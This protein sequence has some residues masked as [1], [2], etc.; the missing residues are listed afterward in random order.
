MTEAALA[1]V[2]L[3]VLVRTVLEVCPYLWRLAT[4]PMVDQGEI[5][6]IEAEIERTSR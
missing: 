5:Y 2:A 4:E 1:T 6:R 3:L